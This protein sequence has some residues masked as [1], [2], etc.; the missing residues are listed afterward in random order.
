MTDTWEIFDIWDSKEESRTNNE[1][2]CIGELM[3][4]GYS[5]VHLRG[6]YESN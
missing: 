4:D 3:W 1:L 6:K 5:G 2:V